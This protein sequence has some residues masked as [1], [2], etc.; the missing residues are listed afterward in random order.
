MSNDFLSDEYTGDTRASHKG[1]GPEESKSHNEF[2][3]HDDLDKSDKSERTAEDLNTKVG[4]I[5][6]ELLRH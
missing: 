1:P 5:A 3:V 6:V 2:I 4:L